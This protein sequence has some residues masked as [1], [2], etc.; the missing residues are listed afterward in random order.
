MAK[1]D[2]LSLLV[3]G[4][5][6]AGLFA[7][8][9]APAHAFHGTLINCSPTA[10]IAIPAAFSPGLTCADAANKIKVAATA[11]SGN[12]LDQCTANNLA[13]WD[14]WAANKYGSKISGAAAASI[15]KVDVVI[16]GSSIGSCNLAGDY[17]SVI[18]S[19]AGKLTFY[20]ST[21]LN[22]VKG[23]KGAFYAR[24]AGDALS[25]SAVARGIMT[26]GIAVG[27]QI[28]IVFG[29]DPSGTTQCGAYGCNGLIFA[30]NIG[31][32]CP[33]DS[34]SS[35]EAHPITTLDLRTDAYSK[36][37]IYLPNNADCTGPGTPYFCCTD[38]GTGTCS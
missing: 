8:T 11:R 13:P 12:Q 37:I 25:A 23:G 17:G 18:A 26:K 10:G 7:S 1:R 4:F 5:A 21:G 19:G 29:I 33:P 27:A 14:S 32:L 31:Y 28:E 22:K 36:V 35:G 38:V 6:T 20:D 3:A 2:V 34:F 9:A 16:K 15:S 30:C 24:I